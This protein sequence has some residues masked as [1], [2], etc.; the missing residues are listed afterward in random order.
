MSN[1]KRYLN[2][3]TFESE[4]PSDGSIVKYKPITTGQ[5]K[6]L[7]LYETSDDPSSIEEALDELIN[8]C[9]VFPED[10]DVK[11]MYLQDRF[12]LLVEIRR[13]TKGSN[14]TFQTKCPECDS[15]TS[16]TINLGELPLKKMDRI[17]ISPP[18]EEEP[19]DKTPKKKAK[20]GSSIS[21]IEV[22]KEPKKVEIITTKVDDDWNI[23]KINDNLYIRIEL[24]TRQIQLDAL[25]ILKNSTKN[26]ELTEL[27]R[28][29]MLSTITNALCIKSVIT[30]EG[31]E[32]IDI[33]DRIY[34]LDNLTQDE[35]AKLTEWFESKDFGLDFT[36][37]IKCEHCGN[38]TKR[39]IPLDSFFY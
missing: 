15:Q 36:I 25:E 14:Y 18:I 7:L 2:M 12:F 6:K 1:F 31:E 38:S 28:A 39:E 4:L 17:K 19:V 20:K 16:H 35:M 34:L 9:V 13:A 5:I 8:E 30:P 37:P 21:L 22:G 32:E 10:F 29:V 11:S 24:I 26:T 33:N 3:Y 27:Q 23:I